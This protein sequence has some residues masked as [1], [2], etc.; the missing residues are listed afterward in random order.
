MTTPTGKRA[1]VLR[2]VL[3]T[4]VDIV[5]PV[6]AYFGLRALAVPSFWALTVGGALSILSLVVS[7]VRQRRLNN[8]SIL[9]LIMFAV[10]IAVTF[11]T[12]D[13]RILLIKPS[14]FFLSVGMYLLV[15]CFVGRPAMY[16]FIKPVA[17]GGDQEKLT[18]YELTWQRVPKFRKMMRVM[19]A[20][21]GVTWIV[22]S[23]ARVLIVYSFPQERI[24]EALIWTIVA[25][26][27]LV[28]PVAGFTALYGRRL[29]TVGEEFNQRLNAEQ[30]L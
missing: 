29:R 3:P 17:A 24:G 19:T 21:W 8:V 14:F 12:H 23:V 4:L 20:V 13:P 11:L 10:G 2:S 15:S 25:I 16:E 7:A 18:R 5:V 6:L 28:L 22:E 27:A 30:R 9:V 26:V 1:S